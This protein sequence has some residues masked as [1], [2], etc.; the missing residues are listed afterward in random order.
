M[1]NRKSMLSRRRF[2]G[3]AAAL[4]I[5]ASL[6]VVPGAWA[7]DPYP[8]KPIKIVVP[9]AAGGSGDV[10][11]RLVAQHLGVRLGQQVLVE[12][13]PGAGGVTGVGVAAKSPADGY[14]LG[15]VSSGYAWLAALYPNLTFDP[16]KDLTPVALICSVPYVF[17][18]R[19]DAP[20]KTVPEFVAYAKANPNKLSLASAGVGTLTHLLPAWLFA[21]N[22]LQIAH[23]PYGGTAPAMNS[24][25]AG[26]TD[27][28]FD[29]VATSMPQVRAGR[30]RALATT[31]TKRTKSSDDVPTLNELGYQARGSTWFGLMAPTGTPKDIID[32]LN[33]EVNAVLQEDEV[34]KR[35]QAGDFADESG[36]IQKF[37]AFLE[38][39]TAIWTKIVK[40][41]NIKSD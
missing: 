19:N 22:G 30:V 32:R 7:A 4:A 41:N 27:I 26:Q 35:L 23:I 28:Y 36:S 14:T 1:N 2:N 6:G 38:S 15:F 31:G 40:D 37:S 33:R 21:E 8:N 39:E 12:N 9:F 24:L 10:V 13:R 25:V 11:T 20:F 34:K 16:A 17:L 18:T 5:A 29:P 3:V